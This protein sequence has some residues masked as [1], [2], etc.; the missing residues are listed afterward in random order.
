MAYIEWAFE[1]QSVEGL[2]FW[3]ETGGR[4]TLS[5]TNPTN[6]EKS[7]RL[8]QYRD[9][10]GKEGGAPLMSGEN[11]QAFKNVAEKMGNN[12]HLSD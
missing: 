5:P 11:L 12:P 10:F 1:E 3:I 8:M 7:S 6:R 9:S 2:E 4:T